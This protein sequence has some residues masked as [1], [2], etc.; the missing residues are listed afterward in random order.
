MK[1][2]ETHTAENQSQTSQIIAPGEPAIDTTEQLEALAS[3]IQSD[4]ARF[5]ECDR[6]IVDWSKKQLTAAIEIGKSL[7]KAKEVIP[8]G[9]FRSWCSQ[10]VK[11]VEHRTLTRYMRLA[12]KETHVSDCTSLRQAYLKCTV[13]RKS[14][15]SEVPSD[16][17]TAKNHLKKVCELLSKHS[18]LVADPDSDAI[19]DFLDQVN[20]WTAT[21][22]GQQTDRISFAHV[23]RPESNRQ[24]AA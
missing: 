14:R 6:G 3:K 19:L 21:Y 8:H 4:L 10:T 12:E 15:V 2:T 24:A 16:F 5:A 9:K 7:S 13:P 11:G 22:R 20:A 18:G 17:L 1:T 23:C